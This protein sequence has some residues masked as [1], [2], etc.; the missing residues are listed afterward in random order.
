MRL[1][2]PAFHCNFDSSFR[3]EEDS[4]G[5][6]LC[7]RWES[8]EKINTKVESNSRLSAPV[9][10]CQWLGYNRVHIRES[11]VFSTYPGKRVEYMRYE[12]NSTTGCELEN[13]SRQIVGYGDWELE[14]HSKGD[15]ILAKL[16]IN[17]RKVMIRSRL[18]QVNILEDKESINWLFKSVDPIYFFDLNLLNMCIEHLTV[19][20]EYDM[21]EIKSETI[22][23]GGESIRLSNEKLN[24]DHVPDSKVEE[25]LLRMVTGY[26]GNVISDMIRKELDVEAKWNEFFKHSGP[27]IRKVC[28]WNDIKEFCLI[29]PS[30]ILHKNSCTLP[31]VDHIISSDHKTLK[32]ALYPFESTQAD[33]DLIEFSKFKSC[34]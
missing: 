8:K 34:K 10:G 18:N 6:T 2:F 26:S 29:P 19:I 17:W 21:S 4:I 5:A 16:S 14:S 25:A 15:S 13:Y 32:I 30:E 23:V 31:S 1:C 20:P 3:S 9:L 33:T 7:G 22:K 28:R 27:R 11:R 12:Y 24:V